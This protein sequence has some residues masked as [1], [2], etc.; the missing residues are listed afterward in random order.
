MRHLITFLTLLT[1]LNAYGVSFIDKSETKFFPKEFG[2]K[3]A[4]FKAFPTFWWNFAVIEADSDKDKLEVAGSICDAMKKVP[5]FAQVECKP[6]PASYHPIV[7]DWVKDMPVRTGPPDAMEFRQKMNVALGKLSLPI[8]KPLFELLRTDPLATYE[9][10]REHAERRLRLGLPLK[11][12]YF[13]DS[14]TGRILVPFQIGFAPSEADTLSLRF[15]ELQS[16]CTDNPHCKKLVF[17]GPHAS[18]LEN[19]SQIRT[20]MRTVSWTGIAIL[21]LSCL[22]VVYAKKGRLALLFIPVLGATLL[23]AL[24]MVVFFGKIHGLTLS[25]GPGIIGMIIDYGLQAAFNAKSQNVWKSN[26]FGFLTTFFC[27][28]VISFSKIPLLNELMYFSLFGFSYGYLFLYLFRHWIQTTVAQT[29]HSF[30]LRFHRVLFSMSMACALCGLVLPFVVTPKLDLKQF[31]FQAPQTAKIAEWFY[32]KSFKQP[33]LFEVQETKNLFISEGA[34]KAFSDKTK[35]LFES[36]I[37]YVPPPTEQA[38]HLAQWKAVQCSKHSL[39]S[40]LSVQETTLFQPFLKVIDC[41]AL[42]PRLLDG[43]TVPKYVQ[44]LHQNGRWLTLWFPSNN[45]EADLVRADFP[46]VRSLGEII[47]TFPKLLTQELRWMFPLSILLIVGILFL[48]YRNVYHSLLALFPFLCGLGLVLVA[49]V[50][51]KMPLSFISL[52]CLIMILGFSVDYAVFAIDS[53][54]GRLEDPRATASGLAYASATTFLGFLPLLFCSHGILKQLGLSL[55]L[56][57]IG[58]VIGAFGGIPGLLK[59]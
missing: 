3:L 20:D 2:E 4:L 59:K 14:E 1:T 28:I 10:L 40:K 12:G 36:A 43:D 15:K 19:K 6:D 35:I 31:D 25:F 7:K 39:A 22:F 9:E 8:P 13:Q 46:E 32:L 45:Q 30:S 49:S 41:E 16:L 5:E 18:A 54:L 24:T 48:Y 56:G 53:G 42:Q 17:F 52:I 57:L 38:L 29:P 34:R 21:L 23:S 11:Q 50:F 44:H 37:Q 26:T 27:L 51:F 47:S 55:C 33:P 58:T